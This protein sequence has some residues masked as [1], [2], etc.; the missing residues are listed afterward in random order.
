LKRDSIS[1]TTPAIASAFIRRACSLSMTGEPL[2]RDLLPLSEHHGN[3]AL[4][5]GGKSLLGCVLSG[6]AV[7]AA[8]RLFGTT[9]I[10]VRPASL[11]SYGGGQL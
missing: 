3:C 7:S 9:K 6:R 11:H 4:D 2:A 5:F 1:I 10:V 8:F